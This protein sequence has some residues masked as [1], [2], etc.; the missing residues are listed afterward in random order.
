M[1]VLVAGG[2]PGE[3]YLGFR[4]AAEHAW[5]AGNS[6][7]KVHG[8]GKLK[9]NAFGLHDMAGN[10]MEWVGDWK[11]AYPASGTADFAGARD[12]G[13][14][15]DSPVKGGA[16]KFGLREL[17]PATR[18]GVYASIRSSKSEYV[19]F[20]CAL[21]AVANPRFSTPGGGLAT[22]DPV[23]LHPPAHPQPRGG[24]ARQAGI[25]QRLHGEPAP[26]L[27]GLPARTRPGS[28]SSRTSPMS[29]IPSISPDGAWVA[30]GTAVEGT[31]GRF[32]HPGAQ[33]G[34]DR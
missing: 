25:R 32:P 5:Y 22:T 27:R 30:Y 24:P 8:V 6:G 1:G 20:R 26:G 19:G 9:A 34:Q 18:T 17:R 28:T 3:F 15:G 7:N 29:S 21:G 16:F 11:A 10:V 23:R 33:P 14:E 13:P 2:E 12:P 31:R 4:A